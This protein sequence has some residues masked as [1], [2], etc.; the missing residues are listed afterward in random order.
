MA[1]AELPD[2]WRCESCGDVL[3]YEEFMWGDGRC[4]PCQDADRWYD[5]SIDDSLEEGTIE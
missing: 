3:T 5:D 1:K 4:G 2:D